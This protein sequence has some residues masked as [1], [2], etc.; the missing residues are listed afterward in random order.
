[1]ARGKV[2]CRKLPG[3]LEPSVFQR[4]SQLRIRP[5]IINFFGNVM[6]IQRIETQ[7]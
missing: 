3:L 1:M 2:L 4:L 6:G 7:R 5:D